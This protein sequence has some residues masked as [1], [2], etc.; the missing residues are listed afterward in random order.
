M[1]VLE[2]NRGKKLTV[3]DIIELS[4]KEEYS[5]GHHYF[6]VHGVSEAF[7]VNAIA[8][9]SEILDALFDDPLHKLIKGIILIDEEIYCITTQS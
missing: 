1:R 4:K 8:S 6:S 2:D 5:H 3:D 9:F 7:I